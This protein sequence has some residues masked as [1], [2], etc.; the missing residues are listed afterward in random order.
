MCVGGNHFE[1]EGQIKVILSKNMTDKL[2]N[3]KS[4]R[5]RKLRVNVDKNIENMW[6]RQPFFC[7]LYLKVKDTKDRM[8]SDRSE[9]STPILCKDKRE[10]NLHSKVEQSSMFHISG[11]AK[12]IHFQESLQYSFIK[13]NICHVQI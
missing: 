1:F 3:S 2:L 13:K 9:F 11:Q 5:N 4:C 8:L 7:F 6:F 10:K 12:Y